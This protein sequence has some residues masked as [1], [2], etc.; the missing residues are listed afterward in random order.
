MPAFIVPFFFVLEPL[1][2][3]V[4]LQLPKGGTW[5]EV[6]VVVAFCFLAIAALAAGLQGWLLMKTN[7]VERVMLLV[8]GLLIIVPAARLDYVGIALF[9]LAFAIQLVRRRRAPAAT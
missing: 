6:S 4:L 8:A 9:A 3:G 7:L 5:G 2:A 1:G